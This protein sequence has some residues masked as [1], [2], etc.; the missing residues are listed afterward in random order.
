MEIKQE[1]QQLTTPDRGASERGR[2]L[3]DL[4]NAIVRIHK[5]F[6]GKGP[7]K[8]RSHL[9]H[10]VL[11]VVLDGGY[12]RGEQTLLERGHE[13]DVLH[14]RLAL[15]RSVQAE[16]RAAVEQIMLRPVRSFM[17]ANDPGNDLQVEVFLFEPRGDEDIEQF[18]GALG[19]DL[20]DRARRAKARHREV[21]DEHRALRA[22]QQQF[23][24][25]IHR[26]SDSEE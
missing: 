16:F 12:T 20:T 8:A 26:A 1:E 11:V 13:Q 4:S 9:M 2:M 21:L 23:R 22:E 24:R 7:T 3:A 15:Q 10:D 18:D 19:E 17:S 25:A 14:S 5:Q 6:Y